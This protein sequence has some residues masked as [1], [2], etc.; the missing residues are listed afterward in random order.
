MKELIWDD[1]YAVGIEEEIDRQHMEFIK[2]LR[3]FD[4][5]LQGLAP[6]TF[7]LESCTNWSMRRLSFHQRRKHHDP[8]KI[9]GPRNTTVGA[10]ESA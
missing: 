5:G 8:D 3:R 10:R 7:S 2:P 6:L 9:S 1:S 4:V